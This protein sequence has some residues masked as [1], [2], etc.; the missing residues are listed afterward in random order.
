MKYVVVR[1]GPQTDRAGR[2]RVARCVL[3]APSNWDWD[4]A[5]NRRW[6]YWADGQWHA[7]RPPRLLDSGSGSRQEALTLAR[8]LLAL[9]AL[10]R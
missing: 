4:M 8:T 6:E 3:L 5:Q 7:P 2:W 9:E 1:Y 10:S